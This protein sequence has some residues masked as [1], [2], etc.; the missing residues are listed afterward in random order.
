MADP[1]KHDFVSASLT[2]GVETAKGVVKGALLIPA[3]LAVAGAL[4]AGGIATL[5]TLGPVAIAGAAI[6]GGILGG[7][8]GAAGEMA[9]SP[10]L[11][12]MA[13]I[14]GLFGMAKGGRRISAETR[15]AEQA[16][17]KHGHRQE[18]MQAEAM[19]QGYMIGREEGR[20]EVIGAIQQQMA[21][22]AQRE[23]MEAAQPQ[24]KGSAISPD[25]FK[26]SG[27]HVQA[28]IESKNTGA[29]QRG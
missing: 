1:I 16:I 2:A 25:Q 22:Q 29:P 6:I 15:A 8:I 28:A 19:Q 9:A 27:S 12:V 7:G 18:R 14:G 13:A 17:E 23:Q 5:A 4:V 20:Q 3:A 21:A 26:K 24:K 11:G 10:V